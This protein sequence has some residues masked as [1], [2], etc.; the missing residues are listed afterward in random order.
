[1]ADGKDAR[2]EG[3]DQSAPPASSDREVEVKFCANA[4]VIQTVAASPLLKVAVAGA[5]RE[6]ISIYYDTEEQD[7]R[8]SGLSLRI[9]R[10]G[11]AT[12]LQ[13]LK[14]APEAE[15]KMFARGEIEVRSREGRPDLN[16]FDHEVTEKIEKVIGKRP[17]NAIFETRIR[18]RTLLI[19]YGRSEIE[20][21]LDE[22]NVTAGQISK[23]LADI[24]LELKSG[25]PGDLTSFAREFAANCSL[26]LQFETKSGRGYRLVGGEKPSVQKSIAPHL[27]AS[28]SLDDLIVAVLSSCLTHF[29]ANWAA[30]RE[31][32]KP[33]A[34]HQL[35]VAL[36]RLRSGLGIFQ[37][38]LGS[39]DFER[40]RVEAR[41]IASAFGP[42]RESDVFLANALSGPFQKGAVLPQGAPHL[43]EVVEERRAETHAQAIT[44]LDDTRT[45]LFVLDLESALANRVWRTSLEAGDLTLLT[46]DAK[47]YARTML[48]LLNSRALKRGKHLSDLPDGKRHKLRIALKNLRYASE[49]FG[50]LFSDG[51]EPHRF[52][53]QVAALQDL[54]GAHNDAAM[55]DAFIQGLTLPPAQDVHFAAGYLLGWHRHATIAAEADLHKAWRAFK[56]GDEFWK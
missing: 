25:S 33:D 10:S 12:P 47:D 3:R 19:A 21:A 23:P 26:S 2:S 51:K 11:K 52:L 8:R 6:L 18:R 31:G 46:S 34:I 39:P 37:K 55:A 22:G 20:V 29:V 54:L 44:I 53:K 40:L 4:E 45:S 48:E 27:S 16:L 36:R 7:L 14:W 24:E 41:R 32:E 9:R 49:F 30:L 1:M 56:E 38:T 28:A 15:T 50:G 42:A 43:L 13:G 35:R 17:L 5:P